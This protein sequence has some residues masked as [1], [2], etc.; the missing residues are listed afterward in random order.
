[1]WVLRVM[2]VRTCKQ[3]HDKNEVWT[4]G[5]VHEEVLVS[6]S[7]R[8]LHKYQIDNGC[9]TMRMRIDCSVSW[10]N[11]YLSTMSLTHVIFLFCL[12]K[13]THGWKVTLILF[14]FRELNKSRPFGTTRTFFSGLV[15]DVP[16]VSYFIL[17]I[18]ST[19]D[20]FFSRHKVIN[21]VWIILMPKYLF[22]EGVKQI[23]FFITFFLFYNKTLVEHSFRIVFQRSNI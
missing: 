15:L 17:Q 12:D 18:I 9:C 1:M 3:H 5:C 19:Q 7:E 11:I 13:F 20:T 23:F 16:L 8:S 6:F 22:R 10:K 14:S 2:N 21:C 4:H